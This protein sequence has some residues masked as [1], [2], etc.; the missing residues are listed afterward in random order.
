M[1]DTH[2]LR[3]KFELSLESSQVVTLT[4]ALMVV[5]GGVFVLGVVVGKKLAAEQRAE[6]PA[7]DLLTRVDQDTNALDAMQ[8]DAALTFQDELTKQAAPA[9]APPVV[10]VVPVAAPV[11]APPAPA[12]K[13]EPVAAAAPVLAEQVKAEPVP[14]RVRDAGALKDAFGKAQRLEPAGGGAGSWVLQLS[15]SQDKQEAERF[16]AKLREKGYAPAVVEAQVAGKGTWYRVRMGRFA[17]KEAASRYL[18][19]FKR[20]TSMDAFVTNAQ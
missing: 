11:V 3:E 5:L 8:R 14:T 19:D 6:V 4:V 15:S 13:E 12:A 7:T 1:R 9:V 10:A 2:K 18:S 20:E 17:T 16:A